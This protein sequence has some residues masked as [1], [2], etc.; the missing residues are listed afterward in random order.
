MVLL[1]QLGLSYYLALSEYPFDPPPI[2]QFLRTRIHDP[3]N[4]SAIR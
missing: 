2:I 4:V 3:E 1:G